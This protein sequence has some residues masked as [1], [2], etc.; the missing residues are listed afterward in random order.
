M[1]QIQYTIHEERR[2]LN[3]VQYLES[4]GAE[5]TIGEN[6]GKKV[7]FT[8]LTEEQLSKLES[9]Y[10]GSKICGSIIAV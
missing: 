5:G 8:Q 7:V 4:I 6:E 10:H 9:H 3:I 2:P 1:N